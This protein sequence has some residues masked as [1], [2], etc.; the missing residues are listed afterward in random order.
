MRVTGHF[1]LPR[2]PRTSGPGLDCMSKWLFVLLLCLTSNAFASP[3]D[4]GRCP[5]KIPFSIRM[6]RMD[7]IIHKY[8]RYQPERGATIYYDSGWAKL[9]IESSF[10]YAWID[11]A[12]GSLSISNDQLIFVGS[13]H[14]NY[15]Q[16]DTIKIVFAASADSI[17]SL[18]MRSRRSPGSLSGDYSI[19][20]ISG[21]LYNDTQIY[22]NDS[23]FARHNVKMQYQSSDSMLSVQGSTYYG[24]FNYRDF[25]ATSVDLSGIFRPTHFADQ[26][27][28]A[29]APPPVNGLEITASG[30]ALHYSFGAATEGRWL[31]VY[32][33]LGVRI[34]I[35]P[36]PAGATEAQIKILESGLYFVRLDGALKKVYVAE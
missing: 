15:G 18:S 13:D 2:E 10:E 3:A 34:A 5:W 28:V 8:G 26:A 24:G 17:I 12:L 9:S 1:S 4:S 33:P 25:T 32:S 21:L 22:C 23:S 7:G 36:V 19:F 16:L 14:F 35:C 30:G 31:E 11:T 6:P 27:A 20:E 29:V